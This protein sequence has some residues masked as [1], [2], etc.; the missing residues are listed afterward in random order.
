MD[1]NTVNPTPPATG[2]APALT[3]D[4]E[5]YRADGGFHWSG[6]SLVIGVLGIAGPVLG[7]VAHPVSYT[8]LTLPTTER[9]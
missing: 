7:F 1:E 6:V 9:V 2:A 4:V 3:F 5:P 8:H